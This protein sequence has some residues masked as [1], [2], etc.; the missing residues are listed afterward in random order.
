M[1]AAVGVPCEHGGGGHA[2]PAAGLRRPLQR[3]ERAAV[4]GEH[5]PA[6]KETK[7]TGPVRVNITQGTART[8]YGTQ[9]LGETKGRAEQR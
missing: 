2:P 9:S 1:G 7:E 3:P 4:R 6:A 8:Q 5:L